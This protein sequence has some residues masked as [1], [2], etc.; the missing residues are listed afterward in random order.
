MASNPSLFDHDQLTQ[1]QVRT[2]LETAITAGAIWPAFQPIMHIRSGALAGF[3]VLARWTDPVHGEIGPSNFVPTIEAH[4]LTR[5]LSRCLMQRACEM[6][7]SWPGA[8]FLAFNIT[9]DELADTGLTTCI[10]TIASSSGFPVKRIEI[11][12]TEGSIISEEAA[13][14]ETLRTL[15]AMGIHVALD[16]YGTGY[17][18]LARLQAFPFCKLKIDARFVRG[19]DQDDR[20]RLIVSAVIGL[21]QSLGIPAVAEGVETEAEQSILKEFG[22]VYAQG[23]L[24][25][26][27]LAAQEI[28]DFISQ[29]AVVPR[30]AALLDGSPFQQL[31]QLQ[32]L[33][34]QAPVG[35]C[36]LDLQ[37]RHV[38][39]NDLF[40][41]MHGLSGEELRGK[42]IYN[43]MK[44]DTLARV[45]RVLRAALTSDPLPPQLHRMRGR[46][47]EVFA[48]KVT[49]SGGTVIGFSIVSVD[50]RQAAESSET[51]SHASATGRG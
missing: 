41:R 7:V 23:W 42:T 17:S 36:F 24:H 34:D 11:E 10:A 28:D 19:L 21:G 32:T 4:G 39:A 5:I 22:C 8:F 51:R 45:E 40:A 27:G 48:D 44:G 35:L 9:P 3:E 46:D 16:D 1:E 18:S 2:E 33:Y 38:R 31:H 30:Q 47:V 14:H 37:Y 12:V 49:D 29:R 20:K 25:G 43:I 13:A 15:N 50:L 26:K 6:A